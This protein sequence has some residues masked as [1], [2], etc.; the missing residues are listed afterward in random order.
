MKH[1]YK[2]ITCALLAGSL[3][4]TTSCGDAFLDE[5]KRDTISSDYLET[6]EGLASMAE[7]LYIQLRTLFYAVHERGHR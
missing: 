7:S 3:A 2:A 4:L 5:V 6:P 1:T